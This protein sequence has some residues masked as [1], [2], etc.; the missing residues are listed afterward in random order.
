MTAQSLAAAVGALFTASGFVWVSTAGDPGGGGVRAYDGQVLGS[1]AVFVR[2]GQT[3][4]KVTSRSLARTRQAHWCL[5][6]CTVTGRAAEEVRVIAQDV[7]DALEGA[8]PA[9]A[10]WQTTPLALLNTREPTE[11]RDVAATNGRWPMFGVV[12]LE[13]TATLT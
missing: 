13:Y 12:E 3:L 7:I 9:A 6:R 8:R 4:P 5:V 10:G 2:V 1:P 11:D